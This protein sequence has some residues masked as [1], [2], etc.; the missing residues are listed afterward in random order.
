M[1]ITFAHACQALL[2]GKTLKWN[3]FNDQKA[4]SIRLDEPSQRRLFAYLLS[5]NA[6]RVAQASDE[7]FAGL[8]SAWTEVEHDPATGAAADSAEATTNVW[9][10]H[11]IEAST[12]GGLT[13]YGGM[14]FNFVID[15]ENWCLLGQNG[16]G[17]TSLA[18]LIVWTLT[19]KRICEQDGPIDEMGLREPVNNAEGKKIGEWPPLA[20]YPAS[21][22]DLVKQVEVWGR[23][24]FKN[25]KGE[26]AIA[27]RSIASPLSGVSKVDVQ[28]DSRLL[29]H[30]Q[31]IDTGILMP[32]RLQRIGFGEKSQS[33]YEAVKVLTG[34][35]QLADIADGCGNF[36]HNGRR[37]LK[38]GKEN[39]IESF[40]QRFEEKVAHAKAKASELNFA[41][42]YEV[43]IDTP[44]IV[45]VLKDAAASA[46]IQAGTHLATLKS[47]IAA[48]VDT[49]KPQGRTDVRNA[50]ST[51]RGVVNQKTNGVSIFAAWDALADAAES[52][53]FSTLPLAIQSARAELEI[54]IKWHTRQVE[55]A[56][57]R[58]KALAAHFFVPPHQ[59]DDSVHCPVCESQLTNTAQKALAGELEQLKKDSTQAERKL[60]DV[61]RTLD[62]SLTA[63]LTPELKR[64]QDL[65]GD[66]NPRDSYRAA[67]VQRFCSAAPFQ[68]VLTGLATNIEVT[69]NQQYAAL[70]EFLYVGF[71]AQDE[72]EAA[73]ALQRRMHAL[74]R[75]V[76]LVAWWSENGQQFRDA[77]GTL[78][79]RKQEDGNYPTG[80][81]EAQ[82]AKLEDALHKA[83]PL[84]ELSK[85]LLEAATAAGSWGPINS[86]QRRREAIAQALTPL[87]D[88]RALVG[89]E[90]ARAIESLSDRT[91]TILDRIHHRERLAYEQT[92][93]EKK[94]ITV[95]GS[96]A[97]GMHIDAA[98]VANTSWLRAILWAFVLALRDQTIEELGNNPFPLVVLDDP[99]ATFDPRNKVKWAEEIAG[100]ANLPPHD[101]FGLQLFLTTHER[102]FY[103]CMVDHQK[104]KGE[105]GLIGGVNKASGVAKIINGGC[106]E[107]VYNEA[108][109]NNDDARAREYIRDV[110]IYCEDLLKF[111]LRGEGSQIPSL[112]LGDLKVELKRLREAHTPP[113][114]RPP[115]VRLFNTLDGGGGK[116]M[117]L[118][119]AS[120]HKNDETLGVSAATDVKNFW[121]ETLRT[122][123]HDAFELYDTYE[124]FYGEPRTFPWAKNIVPFPNG[125]KD[126]IKG[127]KLHQTGVAAAAKT[128]GVAGDG[129]VTVNEWEAQN[130]I[131]LPNHGIYQLAAGTLDPVADIGDVLIVSNYAPV[132][133]RNL[134]IVCVGN[135]LLARRFNGVEA[136]PE[137]AVLTG[138]TVDPTAIAE[139]VIIAPKATNWRKIVG[140]I[141]TSHTLKPPPADP[142]REIVPLADPIL[143]ANLLDGAKLF[144]VKGRSAEP[145]AL[146]GQYLITRQITTD[147][148]GVKA[149]DGRLIV[150]I[151]DAGTGISSDFAA[152]GR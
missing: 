125:F 86:E 19:G 64:Q 137:I 31:L 109:E 147:L 34:L 120:H 139:P 95:E 134:V 44:N 20:S 15:G 69:A 3:N 57:F 84:D 97:L 8:I 35:D 121:E 27:Y 110:R 148:A 54:A 105:Q 118:I 145:I 83:A 33:L 108:A 98:F 60:E 129:L 116:S 91:K 7:L 47:E 92:A 49:A 126:H 67:V 111:M 78:L 51:A 131:T 85:F 94:T 9:R 74:E 21:A 13:L 99:Q 77:W 101:K 88:L 58:L 72:P 36:T 100:L 119:N 76:T 138:Q 150:A 45:K 53:T 87:K 6:T 107:R 61:C 12:F 71:V 39:G 52:Q 133:R 28:I 115:F 2:A 37:F 136:H 5:Q 68:D 132:H 152:T 48:A 41:F 90:T 59:H 144:Q 23:L 66:M 10:L 40:K 81:V 93:L 18:S 55:D 17:K 4:G 24:T 70:P 135:A 89:A 151:D 104:L 16:S 22:A 50:V 141:F 75:L 25:E 38:Y 32:A 46:S 102:Q 96:F 14:P 1:A 73:K 117:K 127:I 29:A 80:S 82:L 140:T 146:D 79:G 42:Q 130:P 113:F 128:A 63:L 149:L 26:T 43:A 114:D 106:L 30:T 123:I 62:H 142:N 11:R 124:S 65:L 122:E 112:S 143:V 103:Q 56:K